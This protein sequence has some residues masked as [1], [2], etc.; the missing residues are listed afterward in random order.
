MLI[1]I[2]IL[3]LNKDYILKKLDNKNKLI[4]L[5]FKYQTFLAHISFYF[6][7]FLII[8]GL[9]GNIYILHYLITHPLPLESLNMDIHTYIS[10]IP[11]NS[12]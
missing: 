9:I 4:K 7:P 3:L 8:I 2:N 12:K 1:F 11:K 6:L 5:Y 10:N